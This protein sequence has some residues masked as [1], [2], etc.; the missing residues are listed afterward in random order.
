MTYNIKNTISI[1]G[2]CNKNVWIFFFYVPFCEMCVM[3]NIFSK[4]KPKNISD[5]FF[6][7]LRQ[8]YYLLIYT[9]VTVA[10]VVK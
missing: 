10:T 5:I 9:V 6:F 3:N 2:N 4:K 7:L 1:N 8:I